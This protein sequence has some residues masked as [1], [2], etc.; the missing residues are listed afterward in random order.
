MK[1]DHQNINIFDSSK[2]TKKISNAPEGVAFFT[3]RKD[4][5]RRYNTFDQ[6]PMEVFLMI[7]K[8]WIV[9]SQNV[10]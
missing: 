1:E 5:A 2:T 10:M 7:I 6:E 4:V 9:L 3:D 8:L